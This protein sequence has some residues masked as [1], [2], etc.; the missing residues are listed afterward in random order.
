[1]LEPLVAVT[2]AALTGV[3][4][5]TQKLHTRITELERRI[6][7]VELKVAESYVTKGELSDM[8]NRMEAHLVR[9]EEKMDRMVDKC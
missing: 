5:M 2:I 9:I 6:D 7:G 3:S 1:M 4:V 8:M